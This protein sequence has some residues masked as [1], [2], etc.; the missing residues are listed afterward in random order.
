MRFSART[1][2]ELGENSLTAKLRERRARGEHVFD[3]TASNP[4]A[5]GFVYEREALLSPLA[6]PAALEYEPEPFGLKRARTAVSEYYRD[7]SAEV[8]VER[9]CLTTSTSEA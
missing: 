4:T 6:V 7:H 9:I 8:P 3:L 2:W 1:G 5:C